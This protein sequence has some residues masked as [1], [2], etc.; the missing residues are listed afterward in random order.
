MDEKVSTSYEA[1]LDQEYEDLTEKHKNIKAQLENATDQYLNNLKGIPATIQGPYGSGKTHLLYHLFKFCWGKG[2]VG[3]YTHLEKIIPDQEMGPLE[4]ADYLKT[5]VNEE[6]QLLKNGKSK[7]MTGKVRDYALSKIMEIN[8]NNNSIILF[9]DE[10]EQKYKLLDSRVKTDDR[11]PMREV[12]ARVNNGEAGFYLVL[13]FAPVSFYEFS[14]GEAQ[15]GRFL[16]ILLPIVEP[17]TF[18]PFFGETGNLIWWLGKGRYR[19]ISRTKDILR[20]NVSDIGKISKKELLNICNNIGS[21]GGVPALEFESIEKVDDFDTFRDFLIHLEPNEKGGEIHSGHIKVVAK[22]RIFNNEKRNLN[23]ILEKSLRNSGVS[24]ITD[25]GYYLSIILDALSTSD[26]KMPL[27]VDSIDWKELLNI[28]EDV[29]L[30]FEGE[31]KLP[32]EDLRKLQENISDFSYKLRHNLEDTGTVKEGYCI[33]PLFLR[34]IFPFP[35]S[36]PNLTNKKIE[37]QRENLGDQTWLAKEERNGI[38][39]YFFLNESKIKEYL[40]QEGKSF[41]KET[42][43]LV[44]INLG[45]EKNIEMPKLAKWLQNEGRFKVITPTRILSD[46]LVSFLYWVRNER[47]GNEPKESIPIINLLDKLEEYQSKAEKDKARKIAYHNSRI[48]EYLDREL[49][50]LPIS[51][52]TLGDKTGFDPFKENRV[53]FV[54]EVIGFAFIDGKNDWEALHKFR[55]NFESTQFIHKESTGKKTGVPTALENLVVADKKIKGITTGAVLRRI[56]DS[57]RKHLSDLTEVVDEINKEEFIRIPADSDSEQIFEG[58]FLYLKEWKDPSK[59]DENFR[60]AKNVWDELASRIDRL[61][62]KIKEFEKVADENILLTHSLEAD[63]ILIGNIGK[64]LGEYQKKISPYT[65]FLLSTFIVKTVEVVEPKL[66]VIEK[67]YGEF[68]NSIK[69]TI[70]EYKNTLKNIETFEK[71][72]FKWINK[73]KVELQKEFQKNFEDVCKEF[74]KNGKIDLEKTHDTDSFINDVEEI[75][76]ELQLLLEI[77]ESMKHCKAKAQEINEMLEN[78]G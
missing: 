43:A 21:I 25:I 34:T 23:D 49:P 47:I 15:T 12:I 11:S 69:D 10:V 55:Q 77:N 66:N 54:P 73:S 59:A 30:E 72:T 41:L 8:G 53:G 26:G 9:V 62:N 29:I 38:S 70:E 7:L 6:I 61:Y 76:D 57:F 22:C 5:L 36:S 27:F 31:N 46:F 68:Q 60:E 39:V 65:K 67:K 75:T 19:S 45:I 40:V 37:E 18:I 71:E 56:S 35:I 48:R 52:Y 3:I 63:K 51:K 2:G 28:V 20:A 14:K 50:K 74:T 42:N 78:W 44:A 16:P 17:R 64:L 1:D 33:T 58:I 24:K 32:S 4:Y 13:A